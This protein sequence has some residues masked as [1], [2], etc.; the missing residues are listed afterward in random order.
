[1]ETNVDDGATKPTWQRVDWWFTAALLLASVLVGLV[2]VPQHQAIS[3]IDEFVYIDYLAKVAEQGAVARGEETG[4]LAREEFACEGVRHWFAP[5][6][7]LCASGSFE[8]D[9]LYPF[10]G[11]TSADL[12]SPVYFY[13]T[14]AVS[15]PFQWLGMDFIDAGRASGV[16]WLGAA[17]VLLYASMRR[18]NVR[19]LLALGLGLL[20][21]GSLPVYWSHTY[22]STD[23]TALF[24]GALLLLLALEHLSTG[25]RWWMLPIAAAFVTLLKLQNLM[26][27]AGVAVLFV[28]LAARAAFSSESAFPAR[29]SLFLRHRLTLTAVATIAAALLAQVVWTVIRAAI[30]VGP[31]P[32]QLVAEPFGLRSVLVEM[33]KFF[34]GP[35][36]GATDAAMLGQQ[37]TVIAV[38][39]MA[40]AAAGVL[41][42]AAV[43]ARDSVGTWLAVAVV[44][45]AVAAGPALAVANIAVSGFY[46]SLP[47]RY[48][49]SLIPMFIACAGMLFS[50]GRLR[51]VVAAAGLGAFV[52][53]LTIPEIG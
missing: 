24:A 23:A 31:A 9:D 43:G 4:E 10:G 52:L 6:E 49:M 32:D 21:A 28:I 45:A 14:W 19:P 25:R 40:L 44:A 38:I 29:V 36:E 3:P 50:P 47:A 12:Y 13:V 34:P 11:K 41:G 39:G 22:V 53:S 42:M 17:L 15:Q 48:G 46:F 27:V 35:M 16:V 2:H 26:A 1:M 8:E 30:A 7:E 20:V 18:L 51:Y 33:S 37:G 5:N